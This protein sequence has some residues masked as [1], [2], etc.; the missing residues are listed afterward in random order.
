M[1]IVFGDYKYY[2]NGFNFIAFLVI[3]VVVILFF[4]GKFI[5]FM[6]SLS[7]VLWFVGVIVVFAVYVLLKKRIIV[8]K[9][10]E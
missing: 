1:Y 5:Y 8:E 7:R 3:L 9:I 6:E 10:G 4:G 2:D